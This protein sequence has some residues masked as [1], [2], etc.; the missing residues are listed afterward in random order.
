MGD[1]DTYRKRAR[2]CAALAAGSASPQHKA[3]WLDLEQHWLGLAEALDL[4][5]RV[6]PFTAFF[7]TGA[8]RSGA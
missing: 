1:A 8:G 6:D 2:E 5:R 3:I 4:Y 7:L